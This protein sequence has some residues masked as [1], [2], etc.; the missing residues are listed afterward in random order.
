VL[1]HLSGNR[2]SGAGTR[3]CR[4]GVEGLL[5]MS[6]DQVPGLRQRRMCAVDVPSSLQEAQS[7]CSRVLF[8]IL[9][10]QPVRTRRRPLAS[11]AMWRTFFFEADPWN[12]E[13]VNAKL[14]TVSW[15]NTTRQANGGCTLAGWWWY[16][17]SAEGVLNTC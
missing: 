8:G 10:R 16:T 15:G 14:S 17:G 13:V 5:L 1:S 12:S 11:H 3:L 4:I 7:S 9:E 2:G 6:S